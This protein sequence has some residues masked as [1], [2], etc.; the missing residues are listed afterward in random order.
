MFRILLISGFLLVTVSVSQTVPPA[1]PPPMGWNSYYCYGATVTEDEVKANA[2]MMELGRLSR[3]GPVG[4]ERESRF[5][6]DEQITHITL[7]TIFRSPL[8]MGGDL[9][10]IRPFTLS[11]LRNRD[12]ITVNRNSTNNRQLFRRGNH[13]A[14]I[15]DAINSENKYLALFNLGEDAE[16]PVYVLLNDIGFEGNCAIRDLW[17]Q[18]NPGNFKKDFAPVIPP[19]GAGLFRIVSERIEKIYKLKKDQNCL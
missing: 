7:W 12:V 19:H 6:P 10:M 15:A 3:R 9:T 18:K 14:W 17:Q 5:T 1:E 11:L 16:T 8:M 13:V 4:V 2:D